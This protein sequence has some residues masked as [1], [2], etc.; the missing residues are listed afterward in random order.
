MANEIITVK[1]PGDFDALKA[2]VIDGLNSPHSKTMYAFAIDDFMAW[3]QEQGS[4]G[5]TKATV[6]AYKA[7]LLSICQICPGNNKPAPFSYS[8]ACQ[9][10]RR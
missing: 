4:P 8:Q 7:H 2:L 10:S 3:Y 5:L 6:N 9:G 1:T